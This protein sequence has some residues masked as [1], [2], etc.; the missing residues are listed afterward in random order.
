MVILII[1]LCKLEFRIQMSNSLKYKR[2]VI[3]SLKAQIRKKYNVAISEVEAN[4]NHKLAVLAL[5]SVSNNQ[6]HLEKLFAKVIDF[7]LEIN[8]LQLIKD[9]MEFF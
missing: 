6:A 7:S 2:R 3:K 5:V 8:D 1:G 9:K 4:D